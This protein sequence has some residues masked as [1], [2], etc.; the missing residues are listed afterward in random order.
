[1]TLQE[2]VNGG[3]SEIMVVARSFRENILFASNGALTIHGGYNC[4]FNADSGVTIINGTLTIAGSVT[5]TM[6]NIAVY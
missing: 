5:V 6:S 4:Q 1:M 2:A 3:V